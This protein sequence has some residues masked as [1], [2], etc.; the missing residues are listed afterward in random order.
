MNKLLKVHRNMLYL[1]IEAG[2][3]AAMQVRHNIF[4]QP[5]TVVVITAPDEAAAAAFIL[6]EGSAIVEAFE[7]AERDRVISNAKSFE[8]ASLRTTVENKFGG[9]PWFPTG[10]SLKK[11]APDFLWISSETS[12]VNQGI[13]IYTFPYEGP[14]QFSL[15]Q[16][17]AKRDDVMKRMV[18]A[19]TEGSYMVTVNSNPVYRKVELNGIEMTEVRSLWDTYNDYMGGPFVSRA[20]LD[21]SGENII[22]IEGF[23][24]APKYNKR[25][26][27]RQVDAIISSFRWKE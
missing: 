27:L 1:K 23:V 12:F 5:Q 15:E 25:N 9:S 17:I 18:P 4:A 19:Q 10:Y 22:V 3:T 14:G 6:E 16:L 26:Y 7:A 11:H 8:E 20:F 2:S 24:Y 13:F 21:R